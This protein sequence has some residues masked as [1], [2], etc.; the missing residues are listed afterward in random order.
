MQFEFQTNTR[1]YSNWWLLNKTTNDTTTDYNSAINPMVLQLIVGDTIEIDGSDAK[2]YYNSPNRELVHCGVLELQGNKTYKRSSKDPKKFYYKL[3]PDVNWMPPLICPYAMQTEF[4]KTFDNKFVLFKIN[5]PTDVPRSD[6]SASPM[7]NPHSGWSGAW[8]LK[9]MEATLT[10][11]IGIS[12][13][14]SAFNAYQM[15]RHN[16]CKNHGTASE[17]KNKFQLFLASPEIVAPSEPRPFI[18]TIDKSTA[19]IRDDGL[20]I[21]QTSDN[22]YVIS[23]YISNVAK[24][25][26]ICNLWSAFPINNRTATVYMSDKV[27]TLFPQKFLDECSLNE[28]KTRYVIVTRFY[29]SNNKIQGY[30]VTSTTAFISKNY[31]YE[32]RSL[33][34][35]QEYQLL[36]Q[37]TANLD[38]MVSNSNDVVAY[39]M[40]ETNLKAAELIVT[41]HREYGVKCG[42]LYPMKQYGSIDVT[43][44]VNTNEWT[45]IP[46]SVHSIAPN[47]AITNA[48]AAAF[49]TYVSSP[50]RRLVDVI[51]QVNLQHS[52]V[53]MGAIEWAQS[54][55]SNA[56]VSII[57]T[58]TRMI[59]KV[60]TEN[61]LMTYL[62][63]AIATETTLLG[64]IVESELN[65]SLSIVKYYVNVKIT[66][67]R[68]PMTVYAIEPHSI[69][70]MTKYSIGEQVNV[71]TY[72]FQDG[73]SLR[74]KLRIEINAL[75]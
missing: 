68:S 10:E 31:V 49:Y 38:P 46:M 75:I 25:L 73:I 61:D 72:L 43:T 51:N 45:N 13:D 24:V 4:S 48:T 15:H 30:A 27:W 34:G 32:E 3:V 64:T 22:S 26:D 58:I 47:A 37:L 56:N 33:L 44:M 35:R 55:S 5:T 66:G 19:Q 40:K 9:P 17:F 16:L 57:H 63:N 74:K 7:L 52:N 36:Y 12:N 23:T 18:F 71:K 29:V 41:N 6:W 53:S 8:P 59:K 21:I 11:V 54:M 67:R 65:S 20:S 14:R 42:I 69:G 60:Q 62:E 2:V 39:W 70:T 50:L 28:R 1:D